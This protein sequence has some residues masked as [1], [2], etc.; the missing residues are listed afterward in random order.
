MD[1]D[2]PALS[3]SSPLLRTGPDVPRTPSATAP[4]LLVVVDA[5]SP[6][7][8]HR[9][10]YD[11]LR[12]A[13]VEGRLASGARLPST[14]EL[15]AALGVARNTVTAA[16]EQLRAEGYVAGRGGGGT[17][18]REVLPDR[19][20][21]P[22]RPRARS[23]AP[24]APP[25]PSARDGGAASAGLSR[26]GAAVAEAARL[27]PA[28]A[29]EAE[30]FLIGTPAL[31]EFPAKLWARLAAHRWRRP[32][33][34]GSGDAAGYAPLRRAV[35]AYVAA[36]RG[37]R[38][39][40]EQVVIVS[41]AQHGLHLAARMLLDDGD[42][43]WMEDPGYPGARAT[44]QAAGAHIV[45]V[46]VDGEGMRVDE[47]RRRAPRAR[48]AYA[49]PSHQF[50]L[51]GAMSPRRRLALLAWA[52]EAGA[53]VVEDDYDS[54]FRYAGRPLPSLQ[55]LD[56]H[57]RVLYLGSFSKT[58]FPALRL[59]YLVLP[60]ALVDP[61]A[62][63]R[64]LGDRHPPTVTQAVL[65]DFLEEGH[66]QRHLRRMRTLYAARQETLVEAARGAL[67]GLVD[68]PAAGAGMHLVAWLPPG[69]DEAGTAARAEAR[70]VRTEG[71][72]PCSIEPAARG[73]LLLGYAA[74]RPP[75]IRLGVTRLAEALGE[76]RA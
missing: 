4:D 54:E 1:D 69:A 11:G 34:L 44:L 17:R 31:D 75:A 57:G 32:P 21:Q 26:R 48:L 23:V 28:H 71:L 36:A 55:G 7:P 6:V 35:A 41:G 61:F 40:W 66:F 52:R 25:P 47:G 16:F 51:G 62:G 60:E 2:A 12:G 15:A 56:V 37:V 68:V 70:G 49:T 43:A 29:V 46:P 59:G 20:L 73:A 8:L 67:G 18:V 38:C 10:V 42:E 39:G 14:R 63:A 33:S 30:A 19:L 13:I 27:F 5:A 74:V 45:P 58:L 53:W 22:R 3:A 50:P 72:G 24:P 65:A 9:Q 64:A 76:M